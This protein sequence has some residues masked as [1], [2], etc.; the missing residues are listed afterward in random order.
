MN[1]IRVNKNLNRANESLGENK[2]IRMP[3]ESGHS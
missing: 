2:F 3:N 1:H